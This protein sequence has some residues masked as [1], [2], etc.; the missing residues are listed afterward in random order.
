MDYLEFKSLYHHGVK[1]QRWGI[2]RFQNEDGSPKTPQ[3]KKKFVTDKDLDQ[4]KK[5]IRRT[6]GIAVG[7]AAIGAAA[8]G[9]AWYAKNMH[10]KKVLTRKRQAAAVKAKATRAARKASGY[11]ET[12]KNVDVLISR[13]DQFVKSFTNVK[14]A[15]I[16]T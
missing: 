10:N 7:G 3:G 14:V 2:R 6:V 9:A 5:D 1:G 13:G 16:L 15:K 12:F 11:Y 8:V 4:R